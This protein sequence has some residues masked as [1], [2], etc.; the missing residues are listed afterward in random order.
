MELR[1]KNKRCSKPTSVL[2]EPSALV[3]RFATKLASS[4]PTLPIVDVACGSGRNAIAV[5]Q[6]GCTVI[7]LDINL[8]SL[9]A[10][11]EQLRR[12][13]LIV[14]ER[15]PSLQIDLV[16]AVWPFGPSTIA[17]V[18]NVHFYYPPLFENFE[19]SLCPGGYL[20]FETVPGCGGNYVQLPKSNEIKAALE[21]SFDIEFYRER[22]VGP[23]D[24]GAVT[25]QV[26]ARKKKT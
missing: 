10:V 22:P 13:H 17:G 14:A 15:L 20:L 12:S 9:E 2:S 25:A 18:I 7:C 23:T 3:R 24:F 21:P 6:L 8:V 4:N 11:L 1:P 19:R 26:F 5:A 16:A